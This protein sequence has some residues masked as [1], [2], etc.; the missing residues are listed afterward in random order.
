MKVRI[1]KYK[2]YIGPWQI[3]RTILFFVKRDS[4]YVEKFADF[5]N[6]HKWIVETCERIFNWRS[7]KRANVKIDDWDVWNL[8]ATLAE[9]ILP[10]LK[11]LKER[12]QGVPYIDDEDVPDEL[13]SYDNDFFDGS[14]D[15]TI[16][17]KKWEYVLNEIIFAFESYFVNWYDQF[18]SGELKTDFVPIDKN[19]NVVSE[20]EAV[21]FLWEETENST[22]KID[23]EGSKKYQSRIDNGLRLFGKYYQAL[24]T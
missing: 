2:E 9:I 1:K 21:C 3:A 10:A 7:S 11:I 14:S 17:S 18:Q 19:G 22:F 24:W 23:Y 4:K 20:N 15:H 13:K 12:K 8:D 5:F 16:H 6:S